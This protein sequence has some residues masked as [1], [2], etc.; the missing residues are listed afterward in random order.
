MKSLKSIFALVLIATN[1]LFAS[2][3]KKMVKSEII[4]GKPVPVVILKTVQVSATKKN[5]VK[6]N[7]SIVA[8]ETFANSKKNL[9]KSEIINGKIVPVVMLGTVE[10]SVSRSDVVSNQN[11]DDKVNLSLVE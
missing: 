8:D 2:S 11:A 4:K 5:K 6:L 3:D 9:V 1:T 7:G 10:I